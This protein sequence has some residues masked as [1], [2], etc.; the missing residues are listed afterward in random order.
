MSDSPLI[1]GVS[2]KKQSGKTSLCDYLTLLTLQIVEPQRFLKSHIQQDEK[3]ILSL[4]EG[5]VL[6]M[7]KVARSKA[8]I[9][10]FAD[11]LKKTVCHTILGIPLENLYGTDEQKNEPTKIFW[12]NMPVP[13]PY[14]YSI[15]EKEVPVC[16]EDTGKIRYRKEKVSRTGPMTAR[17]VM[18]VV[19]TDMFRTYFSDEIWVNATFRSIKEDL[20]APSHVVFI[21]D[22]RFPSEI[23]AI[24]ENGGYVIRLGRKVAD[25]NHPSETS[26]DYYDFDQY[27]DKVFMLDNEE[28]SI[29]EKNG[30]ASC[31]L[32]HL[33]NQQ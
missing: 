17:E 4:D 27:G 33:L 28:K 13:I 3:G 18:Q 11:A 24:I 1:I 16:S 31:W 15:A 29:M 7:F 12:D 32:E 10:N 19:G 2:G 23:N 8:K 9:Y 22:V 20:E 21:P 30:L 14:A 6:K 25:D 5:N 26:L